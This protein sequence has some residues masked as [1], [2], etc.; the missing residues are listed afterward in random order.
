M[1]K[2]I[3]VSDEKPSGYSSLIGYPQNNFVKMTIPPF[4]RFVTNSEISYNRRQEN[5]AGQ[6]DYDI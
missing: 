3:I 6:E 5:K 1:M 2:R 4:A